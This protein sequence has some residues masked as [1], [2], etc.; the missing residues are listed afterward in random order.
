MEPMRVALVALAVT[1]LLAAGLAQ[2]QDLKAKGCLNCH[3]SDKK[4]VGPSWKDIAAKHKSN[5]G[6]EA[7]LTAKLKE[8]KGHPKVSGSDAEITSLVQAVLATK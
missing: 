2:A 7:A 6:A 3:E 1:G 8:G 4:K 5:A